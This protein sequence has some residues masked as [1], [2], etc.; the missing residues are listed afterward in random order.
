MYCHSTRGSEVAATDGQWL[1]SM[2]PECVTPKNPDNS[3]RAHAHSPHILPTLC[4]SIT[5]VMSLNDIT[6]ICFPFPTGKPC[7]CAGEQHQLTCTPAGI[8]PGCSSTT[9]HGPS[10]HFHIL[11]SKSVTYISRHYGNVT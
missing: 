5:F 8:P 10:H 4:I 6:I 9:M 2:L 3:P 1:L 11:N 7:T